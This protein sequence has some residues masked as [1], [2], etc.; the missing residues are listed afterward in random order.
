MPSGKHLHFVQSLEPLEGGGLGRA[1]LALHEAFLA[2]GVC[3][4]LVATRGTRPHAED[5][6]GV[7]EFARRGP[8]RLFFAPGMRRT[9]AELVA[10]SDVVH[11]HGFYVAS[12]W[13]L[14]GQAR[15]Q[16]R[17]LVCHPHGFFEPWILARSR[18]RKRIV[19]FLFEDANFRAARLWRALTGREADQIRRQG[20]TAPIVVA[21]N[22]VDLQAFTPA[23][24]ANLRQ[25]P[26][27]RR[28]VL[29]LG[30]LH[31]KKG[32]DLLLAAWAESQA[33]DRGW[34]LVLAGPDDHGY[35]VAIEEMVTSRGLADSVSFPG[36]VTG[37]AKVALLRS[38]DVFVLPSYSEGFS[39]AVL[40]AMA[41][42]LPVLATRACNFAE[43]ESDGG[44]WLCDATFRSV[45][46]TL[47]RIL[48]T[49]PE[50]R[51][52]RGRAARSLVE[53]RYAWPAIA[54]DLLD[55]CRT[56]C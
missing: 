40:E 16:D 15:R 46:S 55:A 36:L 27:S 30:R 11:A 45:A 9:A 49:S 32:L 43:L 7:R 41:C 4:Q 44:G 24:G 14:G 47:R 53:R 37:P 19:R 5:H 22:G 52:D 13:I 39:M 3:S 48:E 18:G 31:P 6:A 2:R 51:R 29:F 34:E 17:P 25:A 33:V 28:R 8:G 54:Q 12:N 50:E 23:L 26:G 20:I 1:A 10:G 42:G 21:P 56:L 35:R 38:A